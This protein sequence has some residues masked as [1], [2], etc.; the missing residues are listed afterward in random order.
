MAVWVVRVVVSAED[1]VF[2]EDAEL[3]GDAKEVDALVDLDPGLPPQLPQQDRL[4]EL[5]RVADKG[6]GAETGGEKLLDRELE[7]GGGGGG[8]GSAAEV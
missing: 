5:D 2:A 1:L 6:V 8:L 3:V 7:G 4:Q